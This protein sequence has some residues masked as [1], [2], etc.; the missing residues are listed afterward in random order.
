MRRSGRPRLGLALRG[1][2]NSPSGRARVDACGWFWVVWPSFTW[3]ANAIREIENFCDMAHFS[4]LHRQTFGD[5][6]RTEVD[7]YHV[8]TSADGVTLRWEFEYAMVDRRQDPAVTI[9]THWVYRIRAPFTCSIELSDPPTRELRRIFVNFAVPTSAA[10][11]EIFYAAMFRD[12]SPESEIDATFTN[13]MAIFE[14]DRRVVEHQSP[15]LLSLE[16]TADLQAS[17]DRYSVAYRRA[18]ARLSF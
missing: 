11:T 16:T 9:P 5:T 10:R 15:G 12:G 7:P 1:R 6:T 2:T 18:L 14:E 13:S 4:I 8:D 17:F 3:K